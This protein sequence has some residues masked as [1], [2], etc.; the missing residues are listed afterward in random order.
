VVGP[1]IA[2]DPSVGFAHAP[3]TDKVGFE[4]NLTIVGVFILSL[5]RSVVVVIVVLSFVDQ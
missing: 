4:R 1:F 5:A 2:K 3:R